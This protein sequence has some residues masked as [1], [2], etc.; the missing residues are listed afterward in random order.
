VEQ[1]RAD[2]GAGSFCAL[3]PAGGGDDEPLIDELAQ[4]APIVI[5]KAPNVAA[6]SLH[7]TSSFPGWIYVDCPNSM[8]R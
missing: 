8:R 7:M 2:N 3:V 5:I 6:I 1:S 4:P